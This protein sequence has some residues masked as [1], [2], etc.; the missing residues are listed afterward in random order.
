MRA[1]GNGKKSTIFLFQTTYFLSRLIFRED[2][3]KNVSWRTGGHCYVLGTKP[4][5]KYMF[6]SKMHFTKTLWSVTVIISCVRKPAVPEIE[7]LPRSEAKMEEDPQGMW[8]EL[9]AGG[10]HPACKPPPSPQGVQGTRSELLQAGHTGSEHCPP[11]HCLLT[12]SLNVTYR[13]WCV[14]FVTRR[15]CVYILPIVLN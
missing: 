9:K 6:S 4:G 7:R 13:I 8:P 11:A 5:E 14:F 2:F 1:S 10:P 3:W 12:E 15:R